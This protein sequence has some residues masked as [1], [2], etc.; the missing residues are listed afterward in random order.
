[1]GKYGTGENSPSKGRK[2]P[3]IKANGE[4]CG[5]PAGLGTDHLGFGHCRFHGGTS[6]AHRVNAQHAMAAEAVANLGLDVKIDPLRALLEELW[7]TAGAVAWLRDRIREFPDD[8]TYLTENGMKPRAFLDV[9]HREREHLAKVA[10]MCLD[11]GVAERQVKLA[12]EQGALVALA[13]KA[14]LADLNLSEEQ[15]ELAP[16]IVRRHLSAI[17]TEEAS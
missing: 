5:Q 7:R 11:A 14:I 3:F 17:P 10:K 13:I 9:Y 4:R 8:L 15:A 16:G 6:K 1:M 2:C 12:E